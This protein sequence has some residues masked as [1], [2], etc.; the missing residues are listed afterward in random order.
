M[1]SS[2]FLFG[3]VFMLGTATGME[4][5]PVATVHVDVTSTG[6]VIPRDFEGISI[7]FDPSPEN[8]F[9]G[10]QSSPGYVLGPANEPNK[11]MY[12][13]IENLG[14]GT[15]RTNSGLASEPCWNSSAAPYPAACA[16]PVT[17]GIVDGYAKASAA[18]GW[19][20]IV[21]INL[22]QN[23]ARWAV[24]FAD[25]F[26]RAMRAT[27]GSKLKGFEIGNEPDLYPKE[28]LYDRTP[29]RASGYS[30]KDLVSNWKPYVKV[31]KSNPETADVPLIGPAYDSGG[32]TT[33]DLGA[34]IDGVGAKNLG[35]ATVHYYATNDCDGRTASLD[36]LLSDS[37]Q[38]KYLSEAKGWVQAAHERG[39]DLVLGETNSV[40][41]EGQEGLS[42]T[43]AS[44]AW[45]LEWL[46]TNVEAG[47]RSA[48]IHTNNSYYSP[49]FVTTYRVPDDGQ[50]HYVDT[51]APIYYAMYAF[52]KYAEG[53]RVLPVQVASHADIQ[54]YAV[55]TGG[56]GAVTTFIVNKDRSA[57]GTIVVTPSKGM[58]AAHLLVI[59]APSLTS[60]D[61][62]Y[63][64]VTFDNSTG[65]LP[66]DRHVTAIEPD[67]AGSY[68]VHLP[69]AGIG[70]L[71]IDTQ[72]R[73]R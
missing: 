15:L 20:V 39:L 31:F 60:K 72:S 44:T 23:D 21:E 66:E 25:A 9:R 11:V 32:W 3:I 33:P 18:T 5:Q 73:S 17:Q 62:S 52:A 71:T 43:F 40:A 64:G 58:G 56:S 54:A 4:G 16:W 65:L 49:V 35:F 28:I 26:V 42:D 10:P 8:L 63:G 19:G 47:M 38:A 1:K 24:Q 36:D 37:G 7:Q 59:Q 13:L 30:W 41:C 55:R 12:Q 70:I 61:V 14:E 34:F 68:T 50:L 51:V 2:V 53:N 27:P 57:S 69:N 22:A 6:R 48:Y 45:G 46:F 67:A 29:I